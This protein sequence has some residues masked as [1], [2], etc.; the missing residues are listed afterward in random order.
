[1]VDF[2]GVIIYTDAVK[3]DRRRIVERRRGVARRR[4]DVRRRYNPV[5]SFISVF[6]GDPSERVD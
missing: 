5:N 2:H 6:S 3:E 4:G 1:M